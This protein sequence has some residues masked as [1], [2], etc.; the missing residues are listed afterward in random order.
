LKLS[1]KIPPV[2]QGI[3][4][5]LLIWMLNLYAP[6]YR[7]IFI[8]QN[9][10]AYALIVIGLIVAFSG[11]FV[12]VK[13]NTTVDPRSPERASALVIIGLYKYSRNPMYLGLLFVI[14]GIAAFFGALSGFFVVT[15]F[16]VYI[17]KYQI[18]PEELALREKFGESYTKYTQ[19]VR[20]WL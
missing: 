1:L 10:V 12:F 19:E 16:V 8:Y 13:G 7:I 11:V 18:V 14:I 3:V 17:N 4:A 6:L 20:R 2:A 9:I 15:L 5:I